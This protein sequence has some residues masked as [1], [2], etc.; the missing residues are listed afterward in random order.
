[1]CLHG[2]EYYG[3]VQYMG[4]QELYHGGALLDMEGRMPR[5]DRRM[6]D[7]KVKMPGMERGA[8]A[9]MGICFECLPGVADTLIYC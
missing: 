1:M 5:M 9:K 4:G 8:S 2:R 6:P 3:V 7:M